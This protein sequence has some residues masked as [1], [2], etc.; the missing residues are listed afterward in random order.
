MNP[1][2]LIIFL[3]KF[4]KNQNCVKITNQNLFINNF[5]EPKKNLTK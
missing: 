4:T 5:D 3:K 1:N 2:T